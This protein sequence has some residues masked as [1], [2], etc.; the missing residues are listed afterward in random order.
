MSGAFARE[1][2]PEEPNPFQKK[3]CSKTCNLTEDLASTLNRTQAK[4]I[5]ISSGVGREKRRKEKMK[6]AGWARCP[7]PP[8]SPMVSTGG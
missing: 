6:W 1:E 3:V 4:A 7:S 8:P 2:Y 5:F